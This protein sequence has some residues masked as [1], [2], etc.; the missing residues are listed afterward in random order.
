MIIAWVTTLW[1]WN[2]EFCTYRIVSELKQIHRLLWISKASYFKWILQW[3]L[4]VIWGDVGGGQAVTF[5]RLVHLGTQKNPATFWNGRKD[6]HLAE[7]KGFK[8]ASLSL[9]PANSN[10]HAFITV[11]FCALCSGTVSY[12]AAF[13]EVSPFCASLGKWLNIKCSFFDYAHLVPLN[14]KIK[15]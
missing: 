11:E 8:D 6:R 12:C 7:L 13:L 3:Y 5:R 2:F 4:G 1:C 15:W 10:L 9:F 14:L